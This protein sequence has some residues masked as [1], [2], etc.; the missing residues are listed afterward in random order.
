MGANS[1]RLQVVLDTVDKVT[2]K[3]KV[4][5]ESSTRLSKTLRATRD[6][7]KALEAQQSQLAKHRD[8]EIRV[9]STAQKMQQQQRAL[10]ALQNAYNAT[11]APTK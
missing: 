6:N 10:H 8:L 1:L 11:E 2:G 7:L 4:I 3:F 5:N 9:A